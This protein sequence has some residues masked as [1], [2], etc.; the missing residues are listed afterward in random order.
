MVSVSM[1]M[2]KNALSGMVPLFEMGEDGFFYMGDY[3]GS[4]DGHLEEIRFDKV[5]YSDPPP[6]KEEDDT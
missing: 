2:A 1:S 3:V 6:K 5:Y 4:E